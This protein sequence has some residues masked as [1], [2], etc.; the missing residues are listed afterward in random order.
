MPG[1]NR[2]EREAAGEPEESTGP[3]AGDRQRLPPEPSGHAPV[4][5]QA[6]MRSPTPTTGRPS[7][8]VH[9]SPPPPPPPPHPPP[10]LP[11]P[12]PPPL[13]HT[14]LSYSGAA[15]LGRIFAGDGL[16]TSFSILHSTFPSRAQAFFPPISSR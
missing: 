15:S 8:S 11:R 7:L 2:G 16:M 9:S 1:A 14:V 4:A 10:P 3:G 12:R 5:A 6:G 13:H